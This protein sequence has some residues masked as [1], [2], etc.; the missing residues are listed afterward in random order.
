MS[1]PTSRKRP[2]EEDQRSYARRLVHQCRKELHKQAKICRNLEC[3]RL[4]RKLKQ[5]HK[6]SQATLLQKWR[7]LPLDPVLDLCLRRLGMLDV[8]QMVVVVEENDVGKKN[9]KDKSTEKMEKESTESS[10]DGVIEEGEQDNAV[11]ADESMIEKI[12]GQK[13]MRDAMEIWSVKVAEYRKWCARQQ[14]AVSTAHQPSDDTDE[15]STPVDSSHSL[16][17]TLGKQDDGKQKKKKNRPGQK[18]RQAKSAEVPAQAKTTFKP[19]QNSNKQQSTNEELHP[20]WE[21]RKAQKASIASFQG[22]KITFGSESNKTN[23]NLSKNET[24]GEGYL[25]PSWEARKTQKNSIVAFQGKKIT[26]D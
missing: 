7:H 24:S 13:K 25:H 26:F 18:A 23:N 15:L 17:M 3:Q 19:R 5:E 2:R 6:E 12:L 21:A 1:K 20:S 10:K 14:G 22:K 8:V 9:K 16:F 11:E 4:S